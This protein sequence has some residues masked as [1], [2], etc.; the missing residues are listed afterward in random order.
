MFPALSRILTL[1][2]CLQL[3]PLPLKA[4]VLVKDKM[5]PKNSTLNVVFIDGTDAQK[6]LVKQFAPLWL[7]ESSLK[8]QFF[9]SLSVAPKK[10]HIRVSFFSH[11]GSILGNHGDLLSQEPTLKLSELNDENLPIDYVRRFV[12]HEFGHALGFEHE[13]RNP[14]W[15]YGDAAIQVHIVECYPRLSKLGYSTAEASNRCQEINSPLNNSVINSTIYDEYSIMNYPQVIELTDKST[16]RISAKTKLSVL[17]K[18]AM[19]RWYSQ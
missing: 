18:L 14:D 2:I 4:A 15:P 17:D 16:K 19:Q 10:S 12:L 13:Y 9:D 3:L 5:W 7:E 11:T 1:L 6:S 8:F